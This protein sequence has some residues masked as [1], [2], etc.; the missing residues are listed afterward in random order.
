MGIKTFRPYTETRR[1]QTQLTYE[2]VTSSEPHK[3][4]IEPKQ[5]IS[6]RNNRAWLPSNTIPT[7]RL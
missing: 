3:P 7:D 1:Y 6:G 5:R 2:E 4:L